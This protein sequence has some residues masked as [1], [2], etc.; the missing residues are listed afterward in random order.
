MNAKNQTQSQPGHK[1]WK[2]LVVV[3]VVYGAAFAGDE[4]MPNAGGSIQQTAEEWYLFAH[5]VVVDVAQKVG[6]KVW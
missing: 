5:G 1:L 4:V 3:A 6:A 2:F